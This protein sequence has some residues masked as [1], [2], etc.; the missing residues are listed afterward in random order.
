LERCEEFRTLLDPADASIGPAGMFNTGTNPLAMYMSE[1]CR[2]PK[3]KKD[4]AGGTRWQVP[5]G[6]HMLNSHRWTNTAGHDFKVNKTNVMPI[7][8][9]RDPYTW[10]QSMCKHPYQAKWDHRRCP[11]LTKGKLKK[12]GEPDINPLRVKYSSDLI[13]PFD[14]LAH[15]WMQWYK[16]YLEADYPRLIVRFEDIQFHGKELIETICQCAGAVPRNSDGLFRYVVDSAK[17]GAAHKSQTNMI[18]AMVKYGSDEKRFTGMN[19]GD[20]LVA[21]DV[22]T[23]EVMDLF[24]YE[25]P[26]QLKNK[27]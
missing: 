5:W 25:M 11:G 7:V 9:V 26:K 10:M 4:K 16:E 15:Y 23:P 22:F 6:K 18:S 1:N 21:K 17:W 24:G 3:N 14:S 13:V 19:E 12:N 2:L 20:W 8:A 27:P